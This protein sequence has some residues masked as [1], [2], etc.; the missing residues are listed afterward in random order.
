MESTSEFVQ[1]F[2][3]NKRKQERNK[4]QGNNHPEEKLPNKQHSQGV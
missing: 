3:E 2:N 4:K 1:K